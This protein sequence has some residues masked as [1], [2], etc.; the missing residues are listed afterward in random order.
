VVAVGSTRSETWVQGK[1]V[2]TIGRPTSVTE[3]LDWKSVNGA[4]LP[5][6][7]VKSYTLMA[8]PGAFEQGTTV[9]P[10]ADVKQAIEYRDSLGRTVQVKERLG[11]AGMPAAGAQVI[12]VLGGYR[13]VSQVSYD[14]A[15]RAVASL[16]PY[17]TSEAQDSFVAAAAVAGR[18]GSLTRYDDRGRVT[19]SKV[20]V[21]MAI[22]VDT[23]CTSDPTNS[24]SY[25]MSTRY[26]YRSTSASGRLLTATRVFPPSSTGLA[27]SVE[28]GYDG[29]GTL[30]LT[31]DAVGNTVTTSISLLAA[32]RTVKVTRQAAGVGAS[33]QESAK[34]LDS[35][36][37]AL[38][39][40]EDN[41]SPGATPSRRFTYDTLGRPYIVELAP[42]LIG[43][44][45]VRPQLKTEF[46]SLG[47]KTRFDALEPVVSG[48]GVGFSTR[49]LATYTYDT[50]WGAA[51]ATYQYTVGH[52]ASVTSPLTTIALGYDEYGQ[53]VRRDQWMAGLGTGAFTSTASS[54]ADGRLLWSQF[55]STWSKSVGTAVRYDS[56]G[57]P[58]Q[59]DA[60]DPA[61]LKF[62]QV[63]DANNASYDGYDVQGRTGTVVSNNGTV[64]TVRHYNQFNGAMSDQATSF[65]SGPAIYKIGSFG[66]QGTKLTS[67]SDQTVTG[68]ATVVNYQYD[69]QGRLASANAIPAGLS[70]ISQSYAES[71]L[72]GDP[73]WP[74]G[75]SLG[76]PGPSD[77]DGGRAGRHHRLRLRCRPGGPTLRREE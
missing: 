5:G 20:G 50:P 30:A 7:T 18:R 35:M 15:G 69:P 24:A 36:G 21:Y 32:N 47:R 74:A 66:Y 40:T 62:W 11:V 23:G 52:L 28:A 70:P 14:L 71:Y 19:C 29:D 33:A 67:L 39:E 4:N 6:L 77:E 57:R 1:P 42:Q 41:W 37:R 51:P 65:V 76:E 60:N 46:K 26:E 34:L 44:W 12:Q 2:V 63:R 17:F 58:V 64:S 27:G 68:T 73:A 49:N 59:V 3:Y 31:T 10:T 9:P 61:G 55:D 45:N 8:P 54:A 13:S 56:A 72:Q 22:M 53:Q 16:E 25:R 43:A 38:E 75:S 48:Y